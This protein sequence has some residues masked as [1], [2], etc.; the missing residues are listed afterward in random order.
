MFGALTRCARYLILLQEKTIADKKTLRDGARVL[1]RFR[2]LTK[3]VV[4]LARTGRK[5]S[6][7]RR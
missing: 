6:A 3:L 7:K 1:C 2:N 5:L 4:W